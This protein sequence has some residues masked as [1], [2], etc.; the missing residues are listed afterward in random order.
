MRISDWS[1]D[2]CSSDLKKAVL[3]AG[4]D[5]EKSGWALSKEKTQWYLDN[6]HKN[7]MEIIKP[8]TELMAGLNKVG[9]TML[10]EWLEKAGPSGKKDIDSY[11]AEKKAFMTR[12]LDRHYHVSG[13][14]TAIFTFV[15]LF[16]S[17]L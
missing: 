8:S 2:V 5:A 10:E 17:L 3:Q 12:F 13:V 11:R 15:Y 6:L 14:L 1:S 7:G 9:E 16:A 4:A